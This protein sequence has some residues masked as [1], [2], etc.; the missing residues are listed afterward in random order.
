MSRLESFMAPKDL[1]WSY[2]ENAAQQYRGGKGRNP[3]KPLLIY[4][5]RTWQRAPEDA[6]EYD[7]DWRGWGGAVRYTKPVR[8]GYAWYI[9]EWIRRGIMEGMYIDDA[10]IDPTKA[11]WHLDPKDNLSYKKDT[12]KAEDFSD[13]E[14][15]CEF[16]DSCRKSRT[17]T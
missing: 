3:A 17:G 5:D 9:N 14:W 8:D 1:D 10:W 11:L 6:L 2:P 13:R 4:F 7:R 12:G 15:G 16:F